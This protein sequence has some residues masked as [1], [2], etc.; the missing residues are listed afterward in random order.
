MQAG[1]TMTPVPP[2]T[3]GITVLGWLLVAFSVIPLVFGAHGEGAW[4]GWSG[5]AMLAVGVV[6]AMVGRRS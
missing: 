4:I 1:P 3:R 5:G 2:Q 6:L